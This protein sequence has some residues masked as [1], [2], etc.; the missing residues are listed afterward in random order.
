MRINVERYA[1]IVAKKLEVAHQMHY[2]ERAQE[3]AR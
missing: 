2:Q 1:V 3:Q